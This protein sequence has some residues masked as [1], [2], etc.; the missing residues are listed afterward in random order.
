VAGEAHTA[1]GGAPVGPKLRLGQRSQWAFDIKAQV[2]PGGLAGAVQKV[3]AGQVAPAAP[4]ACPVGHGDLAVV[5]QVGAPA[6][7]VVQQG[8]EAPHCHALAGKLAQHGSRRVQAAHGIHQQPRGHAALGALHQGLGHTVAHLVVVEHKGA[9]IQAV[10]GRVDE[11]QQG[12]KGLRAVFVEVDMGVAHGG[13]Q[14]HARQQVRGPGGALA[15]RR[16]AERRRSAGP[17]Q[18]AQRPR[19]LARA[20]Q[21]KQWQRHIGKRHDAQHPRQRRRGMAALVVDAGEHHIHQQASNHQHGVA[22]AGP[23]HEVGHAA[24]C[25]VA[26][27]P[28][29]GARRAKPPGVAQPVVDIQ[30]PAPAAQALGMARWIATPEPRSPRTCERASTSPAR[31]GWHASKGRM[32]RAL[33]GGG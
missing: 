18:R 23:Q 30:W 29:G 11:G 1:G 9:H 20:H 14:V 22:Q 7:G 19:K 5:A 31:T 6:H 32:N 28:H 3:F 17:V 21:Q 12:L 2:Q 24:P 33:P 26:M 4:K 27:R 16:V 13:R 25:G 10:P 15:R 8:H